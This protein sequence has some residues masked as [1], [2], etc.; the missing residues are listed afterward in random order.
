MNN[1]KYKLLTDN[2][3]VRFTR[4]LNPLLLI[5]LGLV[6]VT[7]FVYVDT[8]N[9]DFV[10]YDDNLYVYDNQHVKNGLT[11]SGVK[12]AIMTLDAFNWHPLTWLSHMAD[13][14]L[15]G[16]NAGRHHLTNLFVHVLN[17]L[18]VFIIFARFTDNIYRGAL[19]A[20]LFAIHPMHVESV[21]WVAER[22]DVLSAFFWLLTMWS[23]AHYAAA[24]S[25]KR[26]ILMLLSFILGLLT[27]PMLVTLPLVLLLL[28]YWPLQRLNLKPVQNGN[29]VSLL[30]EKIPLIIFS[31]ISVML[32]L[33]AQTDTIKTGVPIPLSLERVLVAYVT[34]IRK[35]FIPADMAIMYFRESPTWNMYEIGYSALTL[36]MLTSVAVIVLKRM[37]FFIVGWLFFVIALIPVIGIVPVG[38]SYLADRYTYIPYIGLFLII[39]MT[40][41]VSASGSGLRHKLTVAAIAVVL[42]CYTVIAKKQ[43]QYWQNSDTLY[44][45][46]IE[47]TGDNYMA[48]A[49]YCEFL[50]GNGRFDEAIA[51]CNK[52]VHINPSYDTVYVILGDTYFHA[53]R[54]D[55]A[56]ENYKKAT[57]IT[58]SRVQHAAYNGIGLILLNQGKVRESIRYFRKALEIKPGFGLAS[59]NLAIAMEMEGTQGP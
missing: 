52:A 49:F 4:C 6:V 24:P 33:Y 26:Y 8:R 17:A 20:A 42:I 2:I 54:F 22:K 18:L 56:Y 53:Y 13:V 58:P 55:E 40:I 19:I 37:P 12:W 5:A 43:V 51:S 38:I 11:L 7:I 47:V 34:Y 25:V 39:T 57:V 28:D 31:A 48:Y 9:F 41:P 45:H 46:S 32:T 1:G 50:S 15:F 16:L 23:Y 36:I 27:K 29:V 30:V 14:E 44:K 21:A 10:A 35:V 3:R 59:K